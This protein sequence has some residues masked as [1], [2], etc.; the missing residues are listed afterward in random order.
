MGKGHEHEF[1]MNF[2]HGLLFFRYFVSLQ[3]WKVFRPLTWYEWISLVIVLG[4]CVMDYLI[5]SHYR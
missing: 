2:M 5:S 1:D 3:L 4:E